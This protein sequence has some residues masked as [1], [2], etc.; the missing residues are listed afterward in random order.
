[1]TIG[2]LKSIGIT[3]VIVIGPRATCRHIAE[4]PSDTIPHD[5]D[6]DF[7]TLRGR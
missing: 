6:D 1:M 7:E 5:D 2:H 3:G 4:L